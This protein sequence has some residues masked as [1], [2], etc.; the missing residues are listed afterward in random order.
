[1]IYK[2]LPQLPK[3]HFFVLSGPSYAHEVIKKI[4]TAVTL[5]GKSKFLLHTIQEILC[6]DW[7]RV[8]TNNDITGV[9]L[10]GAIKNVIAIAS[11]ITKG[12]GYGSNTQAALITR[13]N[14][15]IKRLGKCIGAREKT[16]NGLSGIGDLI[17]TA[18][19]EQSR[20]YLFGKYIGEGMSFSSAKNKISTIIEG[21]ETVKAVK[22]MSAKFKIEMPICNSIYKILFKNANPGNTVKMLMK[23]DLKSE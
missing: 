8:Y 5:A 3:N 19:S 13:G 11:G 18:T 21:I 16:F 20:N 6:N 12:I 4:P 7:F 1:V 15:E 9:E 10:A 23:R 2:N 17:L 14:A 22:K